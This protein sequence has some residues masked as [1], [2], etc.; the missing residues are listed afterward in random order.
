MIEIV[1]RRSEVVANASHVQ[2][3][4][5]GEWA[6]GFSQT[7]IAAI[8]VTGALLAST[9]W[10]SAEAMMPLPAIAR[11]PGGKVSGTRLGSG[12]KA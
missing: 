5:R 1:E 10:L 8:S 12:V 7:A 11:S 9:T 3:P 6:M 2:K 4:T